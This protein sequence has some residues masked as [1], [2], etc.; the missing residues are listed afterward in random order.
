MFG[1]RPRRA[2]RLGASRPVGARCSIGRRFRISAH[3]HRPRKL[4]PAA[5]RDLRSAPRP[6][7]RSVHL[8]RRLGL[9]HSSDAPFE[10]R[11]HARRGDGSRFASAVDSC[12]IHGKN[13][14]NGDRPRATRASRVGARRRG[15]RSS[16]RRRRPLHHRHRH[17]HERSFRSARRRT[18]AHHP[19]QR[20]ALAAHPCA[21]ESM[22][23]DA[24][25][26]LARS[27]KKWISLHR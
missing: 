8:S 17:R 13:G 12:A 1:R 25:A 24:S 6:T 10:T 2:L 7:R 4:R 9:R 26:L 14:S 15:N 20:R 3:H 21:T 27:T 5:H 23:L 11:R 19:H 18:R 16:Q 22:G